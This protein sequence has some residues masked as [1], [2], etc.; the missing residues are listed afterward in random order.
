MTDPG[1]IA[2]MISKL[3]AFTPKYGEWA[4]AFVHAANYF[5]KKSLTNGDLDIPQ[6][7]FTRIDSTNNLQ[8]SI[9]TKSSCVTA[10]TIEGK[11]IYR[12]IDEAKKVNMNRWFTNHPDIYQNLLSAITPQVAMARV[13]PV[14]YRV[15]KG[16]TITSLLLTR[17]S[18]NVDGE[19]IYVSGEIDEA[20]EDTPLETS[21]NACKEYLQLIQAMVK[22]MKGSPTKGALSYVMRFPWAAINVAFAS[23]FQKGQRTDQPLQS[24]REG[25]G[26][27]LGVSNLCSLPHG[28]SGLQTT[29]G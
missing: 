1:A 15:L 27:K 22:I 8:G 17:H 16:K 20:F 2:T 24:I 14:Q 7:F 9:I 29:V 18:I 4:Q 19:C 21:R 12:C 5:H 26:S 25:A 10:T 13:L 3:Q 28:F 11:A 6:E 23:A